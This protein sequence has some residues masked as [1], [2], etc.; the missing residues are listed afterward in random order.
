M[1]GTTCESNNRVI[2][3]QTPLPALPG[4][5]LHTMQRAPSGVLPPVLDENC[6]VQQLKVGSS[7]QHCPL[8]RDCTLQG[9]FV[10]AGR[11]RLTCDRRG[12]GQPWHS[13]AAR[14]RHFDSTS[15]LKSG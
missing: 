2:L 7:S 6:V 3:Q 4:L 15:D 5:P 11:C 13:F 10:V 1:S 8:G 12:M 9:W 14:A